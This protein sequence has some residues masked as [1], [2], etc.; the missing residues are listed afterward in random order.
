VEGTNGRKHKKNKNRVAIQDFKEEKN[1]KTERVKG[2]NFRERMKGSPRMQEYK[3]QKERGR[4][5]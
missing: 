1:I 4:E 3:E 2:G 5:K